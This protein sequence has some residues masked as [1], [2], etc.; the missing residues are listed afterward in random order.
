MP[1]RCFRGLGVFL[2]SVMSNVS[3][4]MV[5]MGAPYGQTDSAAHM[6]ENINFLQRR[7]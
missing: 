3:W 5:H 2:C 6:T 1:G 4:V 7:W